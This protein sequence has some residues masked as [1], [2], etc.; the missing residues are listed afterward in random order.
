VFHICSIPVTSIS[1]HFTVIVSSHNKCP[2]IFKQP[3]VAMY[4]GIAIPEL[5]F[6][7]RDLVSHNPGILGLKNGPGFG[8]PGLQSLHVHQTSPSY[9]PA[10][11]DSRWLCFWDLESPC[12]LHSVR[13]CISPATW[14]AFCSS[15]TPPPSRAVDCC[16]PQVALPALQSSDATDSTLLPEQQQL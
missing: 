7:S 14:Q 9:T 11:H 1:L 3:L 4:I 12:W 2:N 5:I 13:S 16:S 8:T 15:Q 6:Q 10:A